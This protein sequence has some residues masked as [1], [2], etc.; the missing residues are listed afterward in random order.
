MI[1]QVKGIYRLLAR[2]LLQDEEPYHIT[3]FP[4]PLDAI[5]SPSIVVFEVPIDSCL[6]PYFQSYSS[7]T[8]NP[9]VLS[10]RDYLE[11]NH[12][13]YQG[14]KL[15]QYFEQ[16]H[17]DI[18]NDPWHQFTKTLGPPPVSYKTTER[19]RAPFPWEMTTP[20]GKDFSTAAKPQKPD[21]DDPHPHNKGQE[22]YSRLS[23][24]CDSIQKNGYHPTSTPDGEIQ[25]FFLKHGRDYRF[26]VKAGMHRTAVLSAMG[27]RSLRVTFRPNYFRVIDLND[28]EIWPQVRNGVYSRSSAEMF[29]MHYFEESTARP[30]AAGTP[31]DSAGA[32][33]ARTGP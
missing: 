25:G 21:G 24:I 11:K 16:R 27:Q 6:N 10:A 29:F 15:H 32:P 30:S 20:P 28:I 1:R 2:R 19:N 5:F 17:L 7:Q 18:C 31:V 33:N 8:K 9:F 13:R 14:S 12:T 26:I 4:T 23:R 22:N 3:A